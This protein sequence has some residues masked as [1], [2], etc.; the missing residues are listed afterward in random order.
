LFVS[1]AAAIPLIFDYSGGSTNI[2]DF[3]T[4]SISMNVADD[5]IIQDIRV[6]IDVRHTWVGDLS[7]WLQGPTGQTC[8]LVDRLGR[9]SRNPS[10]FW[11]NDFF[12]TRFNDGASRRIENASVA[13]APFTGSWRCQGD[14]AG[15]HLAMLSGLSTR[16]N[17]SLFVRDNAAGDRGRI[18]DFR[19][20]VDAR[21]RGGDPVPEPATIAL[22][23]LGLLGAGRTLRRRA[24]RS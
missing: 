1:Q 22:F 21:E 2:R 5:Y 23:G 14:V 17:W 7:I 12:N 3:Q 19:L 9:T 10:G 18:R 8:M 6:E 4:S 11:T 20:Y 15:D 16:G 24:R 13:E